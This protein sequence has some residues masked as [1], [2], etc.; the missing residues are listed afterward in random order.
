[1]LFFASFINDCAT[2]TMCRVPVEV[3]TGCLW[4]PGNESWAFQP[5]SVVQTHYKS[6]VSYN[7]FPED[8][9][10]TGFEEQFVANDILGFVTTVE[11]CGGKM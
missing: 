7:H 1:M 8:G 4:R 5:R 9:D 11:K 10:F 3:P 6:I 2:I